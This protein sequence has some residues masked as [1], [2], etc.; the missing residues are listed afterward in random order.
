MGRV[1]GSGHLFGARQSDLGRWQ[2]RQVVAFGGCLVSDALT[3]IEPATFGLKV[4]CS[5]ELS[6]GPATAYL[7]G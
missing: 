4:R 3:G 5:T 1:R 7:A 6:Y 2:R